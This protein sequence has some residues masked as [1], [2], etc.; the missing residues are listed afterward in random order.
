MGMQDLLFPFSH[1]CLSF[2]TAVCQR[3]LSMRDD[4]AP[5]NDDER[6]GPLW[7]IG[8]FLAIFGGGCNLYLGSTTGLSRNVQDVEMAKNGRGIL[9]V[10]VQNSLVLTVFAGNFKTYCYIQYVHEI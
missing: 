2:R 3:T 1:P 8:V 4:D 9:N 6:S 7:I 5:Y 10:F